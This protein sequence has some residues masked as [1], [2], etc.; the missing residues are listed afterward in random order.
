MTAGEAPTP[1][2]LTVAALERLDAYLG[3]TAAAALAH[4]HP[5]QPGPRRAGLGG[6]AG[7]DPQA[8]LPRLGDRR[9]RRHHRAR[10]EPRDGARAPPAPEPRAPPELEELPPLRAG[11]H[12]A[13]DRQQPAPRRRRARRRHRPPSAA[14]GIARGRASPTSGRDYGA[15]ASILAEYLLA[16]GHRSRASSLATALI[17]AIRTETQD[18]RREGQSA[19]HDLYDYLYPLANKRALGRIQH[20]RPAAELLPHAAPGAGEH[21]GRWTTSII[22]HL[23]RRRRPTTCPQIADLLLRV[24]GKTWSL[25]TGPYEDRI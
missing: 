16:A 20:P 11:R 18:F 2:A 8:P 24:E 22:C 7:A 3:G 9:L 19:D 12:P 13:A 21:A 1:S 15:T 14:Q 10:R 5:R 23:R 4:P 25:A 17:Y 6:G